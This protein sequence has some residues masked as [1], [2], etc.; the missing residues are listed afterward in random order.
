MLT[1]AC[2]LTHTFL[3]AAAILYASLIVTVP[4]PLTATHSLTHY[5][6]I[7]QYEPNPFFFDEDGTTE[8]ASVAYRYRKFTLGTYYAMYCI[9]I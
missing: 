4:H 1:H 2:I 9:M 8:P 3:A 7:T 6:S 5:H